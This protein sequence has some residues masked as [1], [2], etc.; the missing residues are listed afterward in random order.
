MTVRQSS[1][2][3]GRVEPSV[4]WVVALAILPGLL[5]AGCGGKSGAGTV[6]LGDGSRLSLDL[7]SAERP[8]PDDI[9]GA[10]SGVVVDQAIFPLRNATV[11]VRDRSDATVT[12]ENGRFNFT[13][14]SPGLYTLEVH[15]EGYS[16][17]VGTVNVHSGEVTKAILQVQRLPYVQPY[18]TTWEFQDARSADDVVFYGY[19]SQVVPFDRRP[20]SIIVESTWD[21]MTDAGDPLDYN[22]SAE[23]DHSHAVAGQAPNPMRVDVPVDLMPKKEYA[24]RVTIGPDLVAQP[25]Q[26]KGRTFVTL[27]YVDPAPAGWSFVKG[28][29]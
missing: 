16:D 10:V 15:L 1:R 7:P 6:R 28:D 27:F 19:H 8:S 23:S 13:A 9:R 26:V 22:I 2:P 18:H 29:A 12:D 5:L 25:L 24:V 14:Q 20:A 17:G 4:R 11:T 3:G 21:P